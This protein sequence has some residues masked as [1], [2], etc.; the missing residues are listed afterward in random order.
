VCAVVLLAG[1]AARCGN[2]LTA[3][4]RAEQLKQQQP[5]RTGSHGSGGD[6]R[7]PFQPEPFPGE[8]MENRDD[9]GDNNAVEPHLVAR[10]RY[11]PRETRRANSL[12][13]MRPTSSMKR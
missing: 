10:D 8:T 11:L 3:P 5:S 9:D 6:G 4:S 2:D 12:G 7:G 1:L 13:M